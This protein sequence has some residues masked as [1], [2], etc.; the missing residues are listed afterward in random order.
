VVF[1]GYYIKALSANSCEL[2]CIS[3]SDPGG[4]VRNH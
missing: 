2:V 3:Q 1:A 4:E